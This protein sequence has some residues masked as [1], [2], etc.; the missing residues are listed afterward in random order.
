M[1]K[2]IPW[3]YGKK[4]HYVVWNKD[5]VGIMPEPWNKGK[6]YP[7]ITGNKHHNWKGGI[8]SEN[9][10]I[11]GSLEYKIWRRAVLKRDNFSCQKCGIRNKKGLGRCVKFEVDHI[12]PFA[13]YPELRFDIKNGRVLCVE[14][15]KKTDTYKQKR[16][17]VKK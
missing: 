11:R 10:R 7:Q 9:S 12:K 17:G 2:R 3:N 4:L 14:C 15:H 16:K 6:L 5:Q 13:Y 8:S 1:K